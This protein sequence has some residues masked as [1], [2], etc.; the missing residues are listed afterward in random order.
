MAPQPRTIAARIAKGVDLTF[1]GLALNP[2][3]PL[4]RNS[5]AE[6][7]DHASRMFGLRTI[8]AFY[9]QEALATPRAF[10]PKPP[11]VQPTL[12]RVRSLRWGGAS[13]EVLDLTWPSA[14][15]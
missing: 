12:T 11:A 6:G 13:G 14:F 5:S 15:T 4:R 10:F 3:A 1:A 9:N 7:L 2:P 8:A